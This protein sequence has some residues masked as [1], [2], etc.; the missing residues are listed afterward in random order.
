MRFRNPPRGVPALPPPPTSLDAGDL[1]LLREA[2]ERLP[3]G[4][5]VAELGGRVVLR[6]P[7]GDR[8]FGDVQADA[9]AGEAVRRVQAEARRGVSQHE[10]LELRGPVL[11]SLEV[12]ALPLPSGGTVVILVDGSERRRLDAVRRD[13]VANVNHE[14]RTP[15][16]ALGVLAEALAEETDAEVVHRLAARIRGEVQRAHQV[17]EELLDFS[18]VE[19][20]EPTEDELV[21]LR[22]VVAAAAERVAAHAERRDVS[23]AIQGVAAVVRGSRGQLVAAVTN[24]LDNAITYS[25]AGGVVEVAVD[26]PDG[27]DHEQVEV[28]VTDRG[29]GI[30]A[31]DL[32]RIFERFYRVDSARDRRTG[33]T[34]LG[35]AIV[36]HAAANHGG[37]VDVESTEGAGSTFRVRLPRAAGDAR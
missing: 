13:F 15:I 18:R 1:Q 26:A 34:G 28:L 17:I 24:L 20:D 6:N 12:Q 7:K 16:G 36:R 21:D 10:S 25:D 27:D 32:D 3:V 14:L 8:P 23:I 22:D 30:P 35:L 5:I 11:R 31:K 2:L 19:S 29:I 4:V 37:T 33:G 9:L